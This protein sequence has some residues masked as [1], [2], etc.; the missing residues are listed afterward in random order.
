MADDLSS[1]SVASA[2]PLEPRQDE[3]RYRQERCPGGC[4]K[5]GGEDMTCLEPLTKPK[6]NLM[7]LSFPGELL[8]RQLGRE[9]DIPLYPSSAIVLSSRGVFRQNT[10]IMN[11]V[12]PFCPACT[13]PPHS[14]PQISFS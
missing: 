3:K 13:Y 11:N 14:T 10:L 8:I 2:S 12:S 5:G 1:D 6:R 4:D 7:I 9:T